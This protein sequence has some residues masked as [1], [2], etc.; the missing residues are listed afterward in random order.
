LS[1]RRRIYH[2]NIKIYFRRIQAVLCRFLNTLLEKRPS[3]K[4]P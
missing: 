1:Y 3:A 4:L 2:N